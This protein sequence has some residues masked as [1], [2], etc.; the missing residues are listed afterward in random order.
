VWKRIAIVLAGP[1]ANF[2]LA[3]LLYWVLLVVGTPDLKPIVALP[4]ADTPAATA[5]LRDGDLITAVDGEAVQTWSDLRFRLL[6]K[7]VDGGEVALVT[8]DASGARG[9]TVLSLASITKEDLDRDFFGKLGLAFYRIPQAPVL[10][11]VEPGAVADRAGLRAGDRVRSVD[12]QAIT[13]W[14]ELARR[15]AA[16]PGQTLTLEIERQG[17]LVT[18]SLVPASEAVGNGRTV[19]RIGVAAP[20]LDI[21]GEVRALAFLGDGSELVVAAGGR[22]R[23]SANTPDAVLNAGAQDRL[24]ASLQLGGMMAAAP[25][26]YPAGSTIVLPTAGVRDTEPWRWDVLPDE[27]LQID[28]Q[29]VPCTKLVRQP[30]REYDSRVELWLARTHAYLPARLRTTLSNG[31]TVD[32][33]LAALPAR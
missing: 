3:W 25:H 14:D 9:R 21:S 10:A 31:D 18:T 17:Q 2:L 24:S 11:R 33:R 15:I 28:D 32:Q 8:E 22:I 27:T 29:D 5:G 7:A 16:R 6:R 19:G 30:R 20:P 23:F 1:A 4:A 12:G 26:R 13:R